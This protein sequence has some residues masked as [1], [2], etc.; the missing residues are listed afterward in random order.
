[1]SP[2]SQDYSSPWSL[3]F[4]NLLPGYSWYWWWWI[5]FIKNPKD[6]ERPKQLMM[7][8]STKYTDDILIHD[9]RWSVRKLPAWED[10]VLSFSA[11]VAAWWYDGEKMHDPILLDEMDIE[12]TKENGKGELLPKKPGIDYRFF[13]SPEKY[14]VNI[15]DDKNDFRMEI[16]PWSDYLSRHRFK[17]NHYTKKYSYN[18]MKMYGMKVRGRV[19]GEQV[20]GSAYFQRVNV[21]APVT[22]WYWGLVHCDTGSYIHYFIPFIGPQMFRTKK[23]QSSIFDFGDIPVSRSLL[24]YRKEDKTEY[25]FKSKNVKVDHHFKNDLPVFIIEGEDDE[26]RIRI[27]LTAHSRAC[28]R[29]EEKPKFW[30]KSILF[31]NEYPA[32]LTDFYF[33]KKD[34]SLVV[35]KKDLGNTYANFEHSW[36]KML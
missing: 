3:K 28:Q 34:G 20:T 14:Y 22:P 23:E 35:R 11:F 18:I 16:F 30:I 26:H 24:F 1:M 31:Y 2:D 25:R 10:N 21:N 5:F 8:W 36:G 7:L 9:K 29:L 4:D 27:E 13:G 33:E 32:T 12:I 17:D 19:Y 6:P 15:I